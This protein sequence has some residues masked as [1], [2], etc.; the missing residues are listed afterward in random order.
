MTA[1]DDECPDDD[2][3]I[4]LDARDWV[5]RLT[6]GD[7][8]E[9]ELARFKG[10]RDSSDLHRQ[11]FDR[12][13]F[14]W[15]SLQSLEGTNDKPAPATTRN[16][17]SMGRRAFLV[18]GSIAATAAIVYPYANA[19]LK[20]AYSTAVGEQRRIQLPDGS[21]AT[22]NTNT[23]IGV[24][25]SPTLRL[26]EILKGEAEF[27]VKRDISAA[28][29]VAAFGGNSDTANATFTVKATNGT[30]TVTVSKGDV[31]VSA[32]SSPHDRAATSGI[33]LSAKYQT[34]YAANTP[35]ASA[36]IVDLDAELAWRTGR[37]IF[38][39]KPFAAAVSEL[40]RYLPERIIFGP[41]VPTEVRV[42]A[43]FDTKSAV[44]ALVTLVQTQG[45]SARRL[46]NIMILIT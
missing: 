7:V 41:G 30:S 24:D 33:A 4:S 11:A 23:A 16:S 19:W 10:W 42:S 25:F 38:D 27:E 18:S 13:R 9:S 43:V 29:R 46:P 35:P 12:E 5:V 22:L 37:I 36:T 32:P 17:G 34:R 28:F 14:F 8:S 31:R 20:T 39:D 44:T 2:R 45:L 15:Q 3:R 1:P 6:S 26:V 21:M 40:G